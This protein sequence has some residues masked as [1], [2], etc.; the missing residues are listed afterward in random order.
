[1]RA[2]FVDTWAFIALA[3]RRDDGHAVALEVDDFLQAEAWTAVTSDWVL[4]ETV[5]Q[6]HLLAGGAV[7]TRFLDDLDARLKTRELLLLNV[8]TP[9]FDAAVAE[10]RRLA[11][12]VPRLSLTDCTTFALMKE[13]QVR[14]AFTADK[15][16]YAPG[17]HVGP[18][19]SRVDERFVFRAPTHVTP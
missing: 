11:P 15:H 17:P 2:Y 9:R 5:T 7:A 12:K 13:L 14:W 8:S 3:N 1:V 10:F 16:F 18:L 19:V 6:L 4:D